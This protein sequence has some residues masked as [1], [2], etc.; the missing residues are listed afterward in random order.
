MYKMNKNTSYTNIYYYCYNNIILNVYLIGYIFYPDKFKNKIINIKK[1]IDNCYN[2]MLMISYR[3]EIMNKYQIDIF[4]VYKQFTN[5][6]SPL[7]N[8]NLIDNDNI[9]VMSSVSSSSSL[10]FDSE[11][12][13]SSLFDF[14]DDI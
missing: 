4:D 7:S 12:S 13:E 6:L 3:D 8:N 2:M 9:S 14:D 5:I 10:N 1:T 11:S